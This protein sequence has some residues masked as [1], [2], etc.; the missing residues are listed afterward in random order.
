LRLI[1]IHK[2]LLP[3]L[4]L[5]FHWQEGNPPASGILGLRKNFEA[6]NES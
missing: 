2:T 5:A 3:S 1:I 4:G 6:L